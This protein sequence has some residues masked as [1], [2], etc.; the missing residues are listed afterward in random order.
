MNEIKNKIKTSIADP[1][2]ESRK[3]TLQTG[4]VIKANEKSNTCNVSYIRNDG[5]KINE[6]N[7][8]LLLNNI[9]NMMWFP[10]EK[11]EVLIQIRE[12]NVYIIGPSYRQYNTIRDKIK[13]KHDI[14]TDTNTDT[15]GGFIF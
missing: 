5:K 13:L 15:L 10:K 3:V 11:E 6:E 7:V 4:I 12:N 9:S 8:P 14:F 2:A 1:A